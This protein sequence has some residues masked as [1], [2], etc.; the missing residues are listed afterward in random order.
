AKGIDLKTG[1]P[2]EN[3][4]QRYGKG[5]SAVWPSPFGAH[6]WHP[7]SYSPKTG[8]VYIPAQETAA[9]FTKDPDFKTNRH[10]WNLGI[11]LGQFKGLNRQTAG[12]GH[13]LAWDPVKQKE[14]WRAQHNYLWNG[15][16]LATAGNLVFQGTSDGHFIAYTAD[17]G[18]Q[19]W[20][21]PVET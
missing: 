10:A 9:A 17:K 14:A 4:D 13:L 5:V 2:I 12:S 3:P 7:M 6:N 11:D 8:L 20:E 18:K 15:G 16:T 1:R 19:L 21:L